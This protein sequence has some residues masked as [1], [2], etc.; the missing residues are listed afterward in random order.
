MGPGH[1]D[2]GI[3][4]AVLPRLRSLKSLWWA[5]KWLR[6]GRNCATGAQQV[7]AWPGCGAG[8]FRRSWAQIKPAFR[9]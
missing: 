7:G 2:L 1:D 3:R 8:W 5:V 4:E 6:N 9:G